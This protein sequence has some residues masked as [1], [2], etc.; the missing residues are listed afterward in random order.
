MKKTKIFSLLLAG[1][2]AFGA[3]VV[4]ANASTDVSITTHARTIDVTVPGTLAMVF[5]ADGTNVIPALPIENNMVGV[6]L[7]LDSVTAN[8]TG[9]DW[10]VSAESALT[11]I[12]S[13]KIQLFS[14][15]SD[16]NSVMFT[17][18]DGITGVCDLNSENVSIQNG[19]PYSFQLDVTR[20]TF[21]SDL[22]PSKAFDLSFAFSIS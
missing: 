13:K 12:D 15:L 9:S 19:T 2:I 11:G 20:G 18:T 7:S 14:K 21:T 8:F 1:V 16:D 4:P 5:N 17:T 22:S 10:K 6:N 3:M